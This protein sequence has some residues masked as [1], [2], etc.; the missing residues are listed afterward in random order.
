MGG[1]GIALN[2]FFSLEKKGASDGGLAASVPKSHPRDSVMKNGFPG[3]ITQRWSTLFSRPADTEAD[4]NHSL[5]QSSSPMST[6]L[7]LPFEC[8]SYSQTSLSN[9]CNIRQLELLLMKSLC[10]ESLIQR[11]PAETGPFGGLNQATFAVTAARTLVHVRPCFLRAAR[12]S[13]TDVRRLKALRTCKL[14]L[15]VIH[16]GEVTE[17]SVWCP[18]LPLPMLGLTRLSGT[19]FRGATGKV[20][21]NSWWEMHVS[22]S[23]LSSPLWV[24]T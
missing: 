16:V 10:L 5:C 3:R 15:G 4:P 21:L 6:F 8:P 7:Q 19:C 2:N 18:F 1:F 17:K 9:H 11:N 22:Q 20:S 12:R 13:P 24:V 14:T 23:N